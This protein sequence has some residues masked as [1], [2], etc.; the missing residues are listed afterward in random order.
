MPAYKDLYEQQL[1]RVKELEAEVEKLKEAQEATA[2]FWQC[3]MDCR[4]NPDN[5]DKQEI[6]E[7]CDAYDKSEKV[8]RGLYASAGVN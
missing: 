3:L 8:R 7:W 2:E 6:D 4:D 1:K 5:P